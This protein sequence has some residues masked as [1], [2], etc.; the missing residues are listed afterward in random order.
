MAA[1][2][3]ANAANAYAESLQYGNLSSS[4]RNQINLSFDTANGAFNLANNIVSGA[5][6]ISNTRIAN[7][8]SIIIK[9][10]TNWNGAN[11]PS[12]RFWSRLSPTPNIMFVQQNDDRFVFYTTNSNFSRR[13]VWSITANSTNSSLKLHT[14]IIIDQGIKTYYGIAGQESFGNTGD[15]LV[16]GGNTTGSYSSVAWQAPESVSVKMFGARGDGL[17]DDTVAIQTAI[18]TVANAATGSKTVYF[19][20]GTYVISSPLDLKRRRVKLVRAGQTETII[21]AITNMKAI[22]DVNEQSVDTN[23]P[24]TN[25]FYIEKM[26]LWGYA[27]R[28]N[29]GII[30]SFRSNFHIKDVDVFECANGVVYSATNMAINENMRFYDCSRVGIYLGNDS[31]RKST[32]LNSSHIPLSRMPSSA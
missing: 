10:D 31:D 23:N 32:R 28:A 15:V 1:S 2:E 9:Y 5:Q 27:Q 20:K 18:N 13:S 7:A 6:V 22:I 4:L 8:N 17:I 16:T 3:A 19:P 26:K 30:A 24:L 21:K 11:A 29:N 12:I 14:P 25:P